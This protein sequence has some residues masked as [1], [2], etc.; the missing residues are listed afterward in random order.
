MLRLSARRALR[1][2]NTVGDLAE[3]Q[4]LQQAK[5]KGPDC[6]D[7]R[8]LYRCRSLTCPNPDRK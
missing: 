5:E 2:D 6:S 7:P 1:S 3:G 8:S 4:P